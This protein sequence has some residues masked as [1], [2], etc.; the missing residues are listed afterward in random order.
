MITYNTQDFCIPEKSINQKDA[1]FPDSLSVRPTLLAV[2]FIQHMPST[3]YGLR[4]F[5]SALPV[6]LGHRRGWIDGSILLRGSE[7]H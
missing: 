4:G 3:G 7:T 1:N 2:A 6:V 5:G